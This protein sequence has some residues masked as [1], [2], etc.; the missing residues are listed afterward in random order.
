MNPKW[1]KLNSYNSKIT[2]PKTPHIL[3]INKFSLND[4]GIYY[5]LTTD[6]FG[7]DYKIGFKLTVNDLG[8]VTLDKLEESSFQLNKN[9]FVQ[10]SILDKLALSRSESVKLYCTT[11]LVF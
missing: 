6:D 2:N 11:G 9:P 4:A 7:N 8:Q 5:C 1:Y 10:I 3:N